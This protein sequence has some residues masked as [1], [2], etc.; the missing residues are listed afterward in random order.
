MCV[1]KILP[2]YSKIF[3]S[4]F[5]YLFYGLGVHLKILKTTVICAIETSEMFIETQCILLIQTEF[6]QLLCSYE[7]AC[8][9]VTFCDSLLDT[10]QCLLHLILHRRKIGT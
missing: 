4:Y 6:L 7:A 8:E 10:C 2:V 5:C 3:Q 1:K 9:L